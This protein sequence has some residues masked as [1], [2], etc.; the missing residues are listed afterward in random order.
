V[1]VELKYHGEDVL[2]ILMYNLPGL[3]G[4]QIYQPILED[5][6]SR[7]T[8]YLL[9]EDLN[10]SLIANTARTM[11]LKLQ[12]ESVLLSIEPSE[13]DAMKMFSQISLSEMSTDHD[14]VYHICTYHICE[15]LEVLARPLDGAG[16]F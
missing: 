1:F 13:P 10:T 15:V 11:D 7:Y 4:L 8:H 2:I 6:Y 9:L 5:L 3:A 12:L 14:L 16:F